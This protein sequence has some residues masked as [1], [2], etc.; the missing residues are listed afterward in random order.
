MRNEVG[1]PR[2]KYQVENYAQLEDMELIQLSVDNRDQRA[3]QEIYRRHSPAILRRLYRLI[4]DAALVE[5]ALQQ[6]FLEAH[7]SF[8]NFRGN[9]KLSSWLHRIAERVALKQF[10]NQWRSRNLVERLGLYDIKPLTISV[11]QEK[12]YLKGEIQEWM[13]AHLNR[14]PPEQRWVVLLCDL[15]GATTDEVA[16]KLNIPRGTVASRLHHARKKLR[17]M[18]E[19]ELKR[20]GLTRGDIMDVT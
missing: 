18:L 2:R 10:R 16:E 5:D 9:G 7:R 20:Q 13:T 6:V 12:N 11:D 19:K 17:K 8:K 4:G 15:E 1:T 14:L 3:F